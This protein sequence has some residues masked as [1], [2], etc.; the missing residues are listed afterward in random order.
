MNS[1]TKQH[2]GPRQIVHALHQHGYCLQ[3]RDIQN[4]K[5][6]FYRMKR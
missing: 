2:T 4:V 1:P 3:H 5:S 6:E